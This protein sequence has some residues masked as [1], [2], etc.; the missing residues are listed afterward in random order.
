MSR[1]STA[2]REHHASALIAG[3][4]EAGRG[5]WAGPIVAACVILDP[6]IKIKGI[7]DSKLLRAPDRQ[8]MFDKITDLAIAWAVAMIS[9]TEIDKIGINNANI[10][11]MEKA[12]KKI[13]P[14]P[15]YLLIDA[16]KVNTDN[17]PT[18]SFIKGDYKITSIAAA[19]IVAKVSR[20]NLMDQLD[21][22]YPEYGFKHHKGYGT[23]HHW[24]M[25]MEHGICR[26]HR[27]S[28]KP[29]KDLKD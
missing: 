13:S 3:I 17:I 10:L 8:K 2:E 14:L 18:A 23:N 9:H 24:Q 5:S 27:Q 11:A 20:D 25:L 4:D 28:F 21:E 1:E 19:S 6:K 26:L 16:F 15:D 29:M 12:F 22:Q 7:K